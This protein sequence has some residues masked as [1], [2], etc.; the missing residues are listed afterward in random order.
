MRILSGAAFSFNDFAPCLFSQIFDLHGD[1]RA[2]KEARRLAKSAAKA[3]K[4]GS[5][6]G[7]GSGKSKKALEESLDLDAM[8]A[9]L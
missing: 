8:D 1:P 3:S 4:S 2:A 7:A 5:A 6:A 9:Y